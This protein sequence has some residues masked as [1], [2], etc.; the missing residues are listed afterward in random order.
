MPPR[1]LSDDD[2][3]EP[4]GLSEARGRLREAQAKLQRLKRAITPEPEKKGSEGRSQD[5]L[6]LRERLEALRDLLGGWAQAVEDSELQGNAD[7]MRRKREMDA[8]ALRVESAL[9]ELEEKQQSLDQD[10]QRRLVKANR[11]FS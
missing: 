9:R 2:P 5:W 3:Q 7:W 6:L 11:D 4:D 1:N 10:R 8:R